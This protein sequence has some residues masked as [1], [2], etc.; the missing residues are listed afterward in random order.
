MHKLITAGLMALAMGLLI[1]MPAGPVEAQANGLKAELVSSNSPIGVKAGLAGEFTAAV[2]NVGTVTWT[3]AGAN[4]VLLGTIRLRDH[5]SRLAHSTWVGDNRPAT[6]QEATVAS[7]EV[8][9]FQFLATA[10]GN[11][12]VTEY[13]SLVMERVGWFTLTIPLTINVQPAVFKGEL[14]SQSV[15]SLE[16]KTQET[17]EV[18]VKF[19][20]TGDV[21]WQ[22]NGA[23]AVKLATIKPFDRASV[24]YYSTWLSRNRVAVA[25][26]AV[27]PGSEGEFK[28]TIQAPNRTG[29][30]KEE[31]GLVAE[32]IGWLPVNVTLNVKV[33]PARWEAQFVDQSPDVISMAPGDTVSLW[34]GFRN[35]GNTVWKGEGVNAV[36]LGTAKTLDRA[37][38]FRDPSWLSSNRLAAVQPLEVQPGE[39]GRFNFTVKAPDKIGKYREYFR[40]VVEGIA[41][42][43]GEIYWEIAVE[44]ELVLKDPLRVGITS[45]TDAITV[46]GDNFVI[47]RGSD[48]GLVK[49]IPGGSVVVTAFNGGYGLNTGEQVNDYLRFVPLNHTL[50]TVQTSG[51]NSSYDTFR[52][53]IEIRR[54]SLSGNV[55]VV[56]SLEL[57]DYLKGVAEVP[58]GWP[59]EAQKAQMV[60]ARTFAVKKRLAP[61]ADIFD[62]YDDTRDQVYYGYDYEVARPN[63]AAAADATRGI[64]IKYNGEPISAYY[65][66]DSGGYT[67]NVENVW[68]K[69]NPAQAIPYLKAVSDP[70]A[71]PI[72]WTATLTQDYLQTRFDDALGVSAGTDPIMS[73]VATEQFVSG[74]VKTVVFTLQSGKVVAL[75][76]YSFDYLT[77]NNDVKSMKFSVQP[78]GDLTRPDFVFTGS[79]WG[80]GVGMAQWGAKNMALQGKTFS[81]ILT[82][83]YTGVTIGPE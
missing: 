10:G 46:Q 26:V 38:V 23:S 59:A 58:D 27:E 56:D 30:F 5:K 13:F 19:R 8:A 25:S 9:H 4:P 12:K 20:N 48:K 71:K 54:S 39:T 32:W 63:L 22:N 45:T 83:Y 74:R 67:E 34:A 75:P 47:R 49:K 70:Y 33:V 82:Y 64:I 69:G 62:I 44:E 68:G 53:I 65:F 41:W 24:L 40:P 42:L 37:S 61:R 57:E 73:I 16:L 78:T 51:V 43:P 29:S 2:K 76:F 35:T 1:A 66:S 21:A 79:G 80:H 81:E 28:F 60:A 15:A 14:T 7:G 31:F 3:N 52:G 72:V 36:K 17:A 6:M 55:W 50:L 18:V 11:G 77:N